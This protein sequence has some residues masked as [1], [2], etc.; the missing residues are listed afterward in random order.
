MQLQRSA[1]ECIPGD[2]R[3]HR[4][5]DL[6]FP[7]QRRLPT[8][9]REVKYLAKVIPQESLYYLKTAFTERTLGLIKDGPILL[10]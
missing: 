1:S 9:E 8:E 4:T 2:I 5:R 6:H 10:Q 3:V 7:T